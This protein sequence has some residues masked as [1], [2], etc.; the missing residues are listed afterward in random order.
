[1]AQSYNF[2]AAD[3]VSANQRGAVTPEQ[4]T[5]L[6]LALTIEFSTLAM[7]LIVGVSVLAIVAVSGSDPSVGLS[8]SVV[9]ACFGPVM[10]GYVGLIGWRARRLLLVRAEMNAGKIARGDGTYRLEGKV[11][12]ARAGDRKLHPPGRLNLS[13]GIYRFYFLERSGWV[14]S[15]EVGVELDEMDLLKA[16]AL[17]NHFDLGMLA[18]NRA[19]VLAEGQARAVYRRILQQAGAVAVTSGALALTISVL[20]IL[21]VPGYAGVLIPIGLGLSVAGVVLASQ[22]GPKFA[23]IW[24]DVRAGQVAL[25]EGTGQKLHTSRSIQAYTFHSYHY[26]IGD[27][28]FPVTYMGYSTLVEGWRYRL[29]YLPES[30]VI[31]A[32]EPLPRK[33]EQ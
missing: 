23:A 29:Y 3:V 9:W 19:G 11:Y 32:I 28:K 24:R 25:V 1:M 6:Q 30:K 18:A 21:A 31:T 13:P 27:L 12:V 14:I 7:A 2:L 10:V 20:V 17:A 26:Q 22:I 33:S 15:G 8:P 5:A 16:L 4:R